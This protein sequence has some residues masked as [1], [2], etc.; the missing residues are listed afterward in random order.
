MCI[1]E[2]KVPSTTEHLRLACQIRLEIKKCYPGRRHLN[3]ESSAGQARRKLITS[4]PKVVAPSPA[5]LD[6][7]K[8][9]LAFRVELA[10]W[11]ISATKIRGV[12]EH[13][14]TPR[15]HTLLVSMMPV[16]RA[17]QDTG[18]ASPVSGHVHTCMHKCTCTHTHAHAH[19]HAH[20]HT[21]THTQV[22]QNH[23]C[24]L[25]M[26]GSHPPPTC[27]PA[28]GVAQLDDAV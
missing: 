7:P 13:T 1:I 3:R 4:S 22:H 11:W 10:T 12:S 26:Q 5:V 21:H 2:S 25:S 16:H 8:K 20:T 15:K 6:G 28:Q 24:A 18:N 17:L 19:A 9:V 27:A 23:M 14:Y